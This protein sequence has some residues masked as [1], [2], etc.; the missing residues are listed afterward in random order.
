MRLRPFVSSAGVQSRGCSLALQRAVTDLG[1]DLPFAQAVLKLREH[2]GVEL[3]ASTIRRITERHAGVLVADE[4]VEPAWPMQPGV[5]AVIAEIDGGMVPLVQSDPD[6]TDRRRGK[7]LFWKEAKLSLAHAHGSTERT[8]GATLNGG[9]EVAGRQLLRCAIAAGLGTDTRVHALGDGAMW[10][11]DQVAER[12]GTQGWY[13]VDFFHVCEYLA[14][15]AKAC[16]PEA[17]KPWLEQQKARLK[18]NDSAAVLT[19][20][21]PALEP[22]NVADADAPVRACW[23]YL[24]NRP[25]QLDYQGALAQGLP[26]GSGE[27]ESAHRYIVQQRLKRPG[28]WWTSDN[29]EAMI[30]LRIHRAN[31]QWNAY[32]QD[33]FKQAA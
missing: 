27:I 4:E 14:E 31:G 15:A 3:S 13:T 17:P 32:W 30:A 1:A 26:I 25:E 20:L 29:A 12:F 19:T 18:A 21:R 11:A 22:P 8:Y 9:V 5:A 23:R 16:A 33:T 28:A 24:S 7:R 6:S 2:Y 10:I